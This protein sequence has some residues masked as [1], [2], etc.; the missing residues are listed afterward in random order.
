MDNGGTSY[1]KTSKSGKSKEI[2]EKSYR[3]KSYRMRKKLGN[4]KTTVKENPETSYNV[5][6]QEG[7]Y[8]KTVPANTTIT[9]T[10]LK[11]LGKGK[12]VSQIRTAKKGGSTKKRK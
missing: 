10:K 4:S 8:K 5:S 3:R 7:T 12:S 1:I 6:D 11:G 9:T 2:S